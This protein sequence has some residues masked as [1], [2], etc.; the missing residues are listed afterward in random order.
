VA[1]WGS[2]LHFWSP[3]TYSY[4]GISLKGLKTC[5]RTTTTIIYRP[6]LGD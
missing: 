5:K 3:A 4:P 6:R 2:I 1:L